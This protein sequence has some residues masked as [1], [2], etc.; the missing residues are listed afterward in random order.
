VQSDPWE[1][2]EYEVKMFDATYKIFFTQLTFTA[3]PTELK[4]AVEESAVLHTRQLCEIFLS[5]SKKHDDIRFA[6]LL[7]G[8]PR[9]PR[10][11]KITALSKTLRRRYS[12]TLFD[13]NVM[14]PTGVR[15]TEYNYEN[16]LADLYPLIHAI[17]DELEDESESL[18]GKRFYLQFV[19]P[20]YQRTV[21]WA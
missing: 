16:D 8:W 13:Q 19:G 1:M 15:G 14:H 20:T 5:F 18:R 2:L 6:D 21:F 9:H 3:L 11:T 17:V 7:P 10:Y 12:K 4:N